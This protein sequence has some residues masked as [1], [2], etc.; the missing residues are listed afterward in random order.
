MIAAIFL[1]EVILT[2]STKALFILGKFSGVPNFDFD[3][4]QNFFL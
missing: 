2:V 4:N 3:E 1:T